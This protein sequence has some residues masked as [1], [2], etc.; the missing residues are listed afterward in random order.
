MPKN[1]QV[2]AQQ[3]SYRAGQTQEYNLERSARDDPKLA[4]R[5]LETASRLH[6]DRLRINRGDTETQT[7][8][9]E[10]ATPAEETS[11]RSQGVWSSF[12]E[13]RCER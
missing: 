12:W 2:H 6:A 13:W 7:R 10:Q 8:R 11:A 3:L 4:S 5:S 1:S 9:K